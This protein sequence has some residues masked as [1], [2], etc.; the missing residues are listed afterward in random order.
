MDIKESDSY[1]D[2]KSHWNQLNRTHKNRELDMDWEIN[3]QIWEQFEK[4]KEFR[5]KI[6]LGFEKNE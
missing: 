5:L 3:Q 4:P 2:V 1:I 6:L